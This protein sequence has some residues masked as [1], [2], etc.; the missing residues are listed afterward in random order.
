MMRL[1]HLENCYKFPEEIFKDVFNEN[2]VML[3]D[4][5]GKK[6]GW[7]IGKDI[8]LDFETDRETIERVMGILIPLFRKYKA[9]SIPDTTRDR[10]IFITINGFRFYFVV[11]YYT[12]KFILINYIAKA[13]NLITQDA[14][15]F[16]TGTLAYRY[17]HNEIDDGYLDK[18]KQY[19][20]EE[21]K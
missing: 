13:L 17:L 21:A 3:I 20:S 10:L 5:F 9:K 6:I 18:V 19:L 2:P 12:Y 14:T 16:H 4:E 11:D 7:K 1:K 8:Y 15:T